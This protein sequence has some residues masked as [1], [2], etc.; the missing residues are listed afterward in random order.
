MA[1][2]RLIIW[3]DEAD[4]S[5]QMG[6]NASN[7]TD[8]TMGGA[9]F[10]FSEGKVK[11]ISQTQRQQFRRQ[12]AIPEGRLHCEPGAVLKA[13]RHLAG[14]CRDIDH[15]GLQSRVHVSF[16][17]SPIRWQAFRRNAEEAGGL[18]AFGIVSLALNLSQCRQDEFVGK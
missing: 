1:A 18:P 11:V 10:A 3:S 9:L 2:K 16:K 4:G 15:V 7:P 6:I 13:L 17:A 5:R 12:A 8:G 14:S